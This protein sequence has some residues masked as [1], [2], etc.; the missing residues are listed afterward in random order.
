MRDYGAGN[1]GNTLAVLASGLQFLQ[2]LNFGFAEP[3]SH[4]QFSLRQARHPL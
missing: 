2:Q 3:N 4:S 1:N